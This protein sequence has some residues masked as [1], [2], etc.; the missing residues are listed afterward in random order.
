MER[1]EMMLC[2][3]QKMS[4]SLFIFDSNVM[5]TF[6]FADILDWRQKLDWKV[7]F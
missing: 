1:L 5:R 6:N 2:T 3:R 7:L 4:V